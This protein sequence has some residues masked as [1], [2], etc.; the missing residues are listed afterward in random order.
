MARTPNMC[1]EPRQQTVEEFQAQGGHLSPCLDAA[2]RTAQVKTF[3]AQW[4]VRGRVIGLGG[5]RT[6]TLVLVGADG[7]E[8]RG[9]FTLPEEE[10]STERVAAQAFSSLW[11]GRLPVQPSPPRVEKQ[12]R[13]QRTW[14]KVVMGAGAAALAAGVGF[15]LAARSTENRLSEGNGGCT[16]EGEALQDCFAQGLRKGKKQSR[17]ANG[18]LGAGALLGAGGAVFFVWELP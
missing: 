15:G 4:L 14:P 16:G 13:R 9:G 2:C 3:G 18:L 8:H 7:Q 11:E 12:Q 6:V 5:E 10:A 1:L 17:L